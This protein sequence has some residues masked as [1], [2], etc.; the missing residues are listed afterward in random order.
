MKKLS[1][2]L[3]ILVLESMLLPT[4]TMAD[5]KKGH[6]VYKKKMHRVCKFPGSTFARKHTQ[7]EWEKIN[8]K[9]QFKAET[10]KICP[11]LDMANLSDKQWNDLYDFTYK[12][13]VGG[14][15]P[16]GCDPK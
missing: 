1:T 11:N 8:D 7:E 14:E 16:N 15:I 10:K 3:V 5:A 4:L 2:T 13:G 6:C 9:G 12:F